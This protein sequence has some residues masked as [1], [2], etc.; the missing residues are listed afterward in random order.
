M[1]LEVTVIDLE[2][3]KKRVEKILA[4]YEEAKKL[5][6]ATGTLP[7]VI[8]PTKEWLLFLA[9]DLVAEVER[10]Q[11]QVRDDTININGY[12]EQG[13]ILQREK[14]ELESKV[15]G[16]KEI[17][18][19]FAF[20]I[21]RSQ[22]A[23]DSPITDHACAQCVPN[24]EIVRA[25]FICIYHTAKA[26]SSTPEC[27]HKKEVESLQAKLTEAKKWCFDDTV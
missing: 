3:V 6:Y 8:D 1:T 17:L 15:C 13:G 25:G 23:G 14:A 11:T 18:E 10:L 27:G 9:R 24:G 7:A 5:A 22:E 2:Q 20:Q 16:M 26:L 21:I 12:V 4:Q 19:K